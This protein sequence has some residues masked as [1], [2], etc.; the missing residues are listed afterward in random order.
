LIEDIPTD[1]RDALADAI[2]AP[3]FRAL[4]AFQA[5]ERARTDT[6]IYPPASQIF[7]ALQLT[8]LAKVRAVI[9]GQDPYYTEGMATG[10]AFSVPMGCDLPRSL[11]NILKA[12]KADFGLPMPPS[13]SL[14]DW[15]RNDVLL[16]NTALTVRSGK[17]NSHRRY[18]RPFTDAIIRAVTAQDRPIVF[19]LWGRQ[20]RQTVVRG[21]ISD[22][23]VVIE[24]VHPAAR[25]AGTPFIDS[26]P[27]RCADA[28]LHDRRIWE[29][30]G[31]H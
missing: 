5:Q 4:E 19:L 11:Q 15:A 8:P 27:F 6:A 29:L 28:A 23:H 18:W 30:P 26:T 20:A 31:D 10:L 24:S 1:W 7:A 17:P 14:D 22:P 12:R 9:L 2:E 25:Y 13:G 21:L 16:L 3:S